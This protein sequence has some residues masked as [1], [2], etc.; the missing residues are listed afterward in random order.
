[1]LARDKVQGERFMNTPF[2]QNLP[3][4]VRDTVHRYA[5]H[6]ADLAGERLLGLAVYGVATTAAFDPQRHRVRNVLVLTQFDLEF[7]RRFAEHGARYGKLLLA[8][9]V[10]M[11]PHYIQRSCDT[12]ALELLEIQQQHQTVLGQDYF[13]DLPLH[14]EHIRLQCERE[15]KMFHVGMHQGL[16]ASLGK[17]QLLSE[18]TL[19]VADGLLR[20]LRGMLWLRGVKSPTSSGD[21]LRQFERLLARPLHG[22]EA[23]LVATEP[24]GW[25][26]FEQLYAD[27]EALEQS[28]DAR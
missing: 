22:L 8:A 23:V 10:I 5:T 18:L 28:I 17:E 13:V 1:M 3:Q 21:L 9:P 25:P 4:P 16:L 19:D 27:I 15:L 2:V 12:F 7:I 26:Q 24:V 6:L 11:T 20:V 14:D